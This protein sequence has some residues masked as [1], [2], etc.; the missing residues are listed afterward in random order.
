MAL[1]VEAANDAVPLE[2]LEAA[3][4]RRVVLRRRTADNIELRTATVDVVEREL[5]KELDGTA[6]DIDQIVEE[7][8]RTLDLEGEVTHEEDS[9]RSADDQR[10]VVNVHTDVWHIPRRTDPAVAV[11]GW[12][13]GESGGAL[14]CGV[15]GSVCKRCRRIWAG[16]LGA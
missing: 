12:R 3:V 4:R 8:V 14:V 13:W 11:C 16:K 1:E 5:S 2:E 9:G 10:Y 15:P 6:P 7:V